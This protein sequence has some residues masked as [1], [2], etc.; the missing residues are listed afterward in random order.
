MPKATAHVI[1]IA[2]IALCVTATLCEHARRYENPEGLPNSLE[3]AQGADSGRLFNLYVAG[4][5]T[6][7]FARDIKSEPHALSYASTHDTIL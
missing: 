6:A 5:K 2:V 4:H 1:A 7:V 3:G